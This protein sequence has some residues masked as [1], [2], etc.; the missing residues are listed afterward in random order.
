MTQITPEVHRVPQQKKP[1]RLQEYGVGIFQSC[2]TKSALKK[3]IKADRITVNEQPAKTAT[4]ISGGE[5]IVYTPE[6]QKKSQRKLLLDLQVIYQDEVLAAIHKPAGILVSGNSFKTIANAL[7]QNLTPSQHTDAT[8]P[9]PVHRLDYA[10]TG[11]LLI[12][13]T[14][15]SIRILNKLFEENQVQKTYYSITMGSMLSNGVITDAIEGKPA[16][17]N[18]EIVASV[19]SQR[20]E[21]LNLLRIQ[22]VSGRRHQIRKHLASIGNP[23]LGDR[24]YSEPS[25]LLQKKGMYLH[26]YSIEFLHPETNKQLT[27]CDPLPNRFRKI[28]PKHTD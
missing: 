12:G 17:T 4:V 20:F 8:R 7:D 25:Q 16:Y 19:T 23:I 2:A 9:H 6:I 28:F 14:K 22:P 21:T 18:Y 13:K 11:I 5:I 26:A 1:I 15:S 3:A 24:D 27:L 10:T